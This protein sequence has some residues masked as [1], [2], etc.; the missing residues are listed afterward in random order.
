MIV[1]QSKTGDPMLPTSGKINVRPERMDV[2]SRR[3]LDALKDIPD[4]RDRMYEPTLASLPSSVRVPPGL[5]IL[6]QGSN[7]ACT[8]FAL[9]ASINLLLK[10]NTKTADAQRARRVSPHML[11]VMARQHDEWPGDLYEGSSLR[12]ALRGFYNCGVCREDLWK[13]PKLD[14]LSLK[15]AQDAR[16]TTLGAYYRLRPHLPDYHAALRETG[17][18]FTSASVHRYWDQPIKGRI[19]PGQGVSLHAFAIVGYDQDGFWIQNSWGPKWGDKGIAHWAYEDWAGNIQD[20]W[21]LQLAVRAPC[22][23]GLG[24]ARGQARTGTDVSR[25]KRA[26]PARNDIAGHYVHVDNGNFSKTQ[27][28]WSD[29]SDVAA[30]AGL[31]GKSKDY[32]HFLFYAHGGL[33]SPDEAATRTAAMK[34]VF[35]DNRIYPYSV[36]YDTGLLKT[37]KDVILGRAEEI[38]QRTGGLLDLT[39]ALVEKSIGPI[40]TKLWNEMKADASLPF[41]PQRDGETAIGLFVKELGTRKQAGLATVKIHLAGHSTGAILIGHLLEAL[42]RELP[43]GVHVESCALMAP[44]C[45]VDFFQEHYRPRLGKK[46]TSATKIDRLRIYSLKD[47]PEQDDQVT[48]LYNKSL[49]YLVSNAFEAARHLPILGMEKFNEKMGTDLVEIVYADE[50]SSSSRSTS[51]GG[52]DNDCFT[53]NDLL[54]EILEKAPKRKF[55]ERDL[56]F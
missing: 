32:D 34:D 45:S 2:L 48:P 20:A 26:A 44:A 3:K 24:M 37:L 51:H 19:S 23:F 54:S 4:V 18:I 17:V 21:V 1:G 28:Y 49:L 50:T 7:G 11:Y 10:T 22:A 14:Q 55:S 42:D 39:D 16:N 46:S 27:P 33:N 40:G 8:G 25:N 41:D 38:N 6:D 43:Q 47:G 9:A 5:K 56:D 13:I 53:M 52:F 31:L 36:F 12:G 35:K 15:S 29:K 30:T